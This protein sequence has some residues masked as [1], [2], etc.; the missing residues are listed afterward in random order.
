MEEPMARQ[1]PFR[2]GGG[3]VNVHSRAEWLEHARRA[4]AQGFATFLLADHFDGPWLPPLAALMAAANA[5]TTLRIGTFVL[6]NDLR[7]PAVLAREAATL[8]LL[9][10]GRFE[11][12]I[13]AGDAPQDYE[14]TGIHLDRPGVRVGRLEEA[15]QI[16]KQ[17]FEQDAVTFHGKYYHVSNLVGQPKPVQRPHPP[18]LVGGG[19]RRMLTL[20]A[21]EA[22][23]VGLLFKTTGADLRLSVESGSTAATDQK[24]EWIKAA[25]GARFAAL[26]LNTLV[27]NVTVTDIRQRIAE[28]VAAHWG[29]TAEQLLDTIHFLIG[30]VDH[31]TEQL[32]MWRE[33][34]GISYIVVPGAEQM[35]ALAPVIARLAGT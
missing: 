7:N 5:T 31:I 35:D 11:L 23:I 24:I 4:E 27:F 28:E 33:R 2:F 19:G 12:G 16:I 14:Q 34:F 9:S 15:L 18:I 22:D 13:G 3:V 10:E 21:R 6:N 32:Q 17:Y 1:R 20:A 30:S 29:C 25:A 8:D 26:E